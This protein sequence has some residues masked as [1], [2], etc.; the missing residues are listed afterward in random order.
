MMIASCAAPGFGA[1]TR[2]MSGPPRS[3]VSPC[4]QICVIDGESGLC[5]GCYRTL[6]EVAGWARFSE[7]ERNRLMTALPTRRSRISPAKLEMISDGRGL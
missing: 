4:V 2:R 3:I 7:D 5:L 1:M 6:P